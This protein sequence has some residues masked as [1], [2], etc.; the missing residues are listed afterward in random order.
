MIFM[1]TVG[2]GKVGLSQVKTYCTDLAA[3][4][5]CMAVNGI[6]D[7]QISPHIKLK[8]VNE[9]HILM[10]PSI[11]HLIQVTVSEGLDRGLRLNSNLAW[12]LPQNF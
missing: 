1:R 8:G 6:H 11:T 12:Q 3:T 4:S 7:P 5:F 9:I 10:M 2:T